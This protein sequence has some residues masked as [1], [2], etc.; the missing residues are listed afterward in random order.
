MR[1]PGEKSLN[2]Y[3]QQTIFID[4]K[5]VME[6][7]N[8]TFCQLKSRSSLAMKGIEVKAG[9]LDAGYIGNIGILLHNNSNKMYQI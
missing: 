9:T 1:Y 5:I 8:R 7:P 6:I 2:I 4:T 3:P